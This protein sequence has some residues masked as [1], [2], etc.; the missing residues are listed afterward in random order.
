VD[1]YKMGCET[2]VPIELRL[3]K[4]FFSKLIVTLIVFF[5]IDEEV[6]VLD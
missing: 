2:I 3:K 1:G 5:F 4:N 6:I